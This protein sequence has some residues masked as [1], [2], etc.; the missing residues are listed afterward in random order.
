MFDAARQLEALFFREKRKQTSRKA[1]QKRGA[2]WSS[3]DRLEIENQ[4]WRLV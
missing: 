1:A 4:Q 2:A 3:S